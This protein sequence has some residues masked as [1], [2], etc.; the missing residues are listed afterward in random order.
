MAFFPFEM[1]RSI[2]P[3]L[4]GFNYG[5]GK[6]AH[7][8]PQRR[9]SHGRWALSSGFPFPDASGQVD[10]HPRFRRGVFQGLV[11]DAVETEVVVRH[12]A[13]RN[14]VNLAQESERSGP[15]VNC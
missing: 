6:K 13:G 9:V 1:S 12:G 3:E 4:V 5:T 15:W 14:Q 2:Q 8:H 7:P 11:G 10:A